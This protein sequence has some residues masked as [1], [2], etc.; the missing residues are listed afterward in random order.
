M[1]LRHGGACAVDHRSLARFSVCW[2]LA[3]LR[4]AED[5]PLAPR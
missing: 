5:P 3:V 1:G 4:V 2:R